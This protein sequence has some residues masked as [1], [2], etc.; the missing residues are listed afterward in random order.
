MPNAHQRASLNHGLP[1][2]YLAVLSF[3]G[4]IVAASSARFFIHASYSG[5]PRRGGVPS[6]NPPI[7]GGMSAIVSLR[8][9]RV[10]PQAASNVQDNVTELKSQN[11]YLRRGRVIG[12]SLASASPSDDP[13]DLD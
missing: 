1:N 10:L 13:H 5:V 7:Q 12:T 11:K 4:L 6:G 9:E 8:E 3:A 2:A